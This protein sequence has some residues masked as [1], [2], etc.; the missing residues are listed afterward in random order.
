LIGLELCTF[1]I[2]VLMIYHLHLDQIDHFMYILFG[3]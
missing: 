1:E 2:N 3:Y